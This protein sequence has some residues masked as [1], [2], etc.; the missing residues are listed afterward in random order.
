[1]SQEFCD[2]DKITPPCEECIAF[3]LEAEHESGAPLSLIERCLLFARAGRKV[4][5]G[6]TGRMLARRWEDVH[7]ALAALQE[8]L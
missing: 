2:D 7:A 5:G 4:H 3:V 1:M 8:V 6:S